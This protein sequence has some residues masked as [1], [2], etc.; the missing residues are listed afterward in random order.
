MALGSA[1]E[2]EYWLELLKETYPIFAE[3]INQILSLNEESI[4]MLIATLNTLRSRIKG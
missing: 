3:S 2:T 1:R 4:K